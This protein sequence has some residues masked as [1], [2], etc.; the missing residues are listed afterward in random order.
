MPDLSLL[1]FVIVDRI[2]FPGDFLN[3]DPEVLF[4]QPNELLNSE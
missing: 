4:Y 3:D 2:H 1:N